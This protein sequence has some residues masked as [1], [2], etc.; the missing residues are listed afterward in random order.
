[1]LAKQQTK[2]NFWL[3]TFSGDSLMTAYAGVVTAAPTPS[4]SPREFAPTTRGGLEWPKWG[5]YFESRGNQGEKCDMEAACRL[6]DYLDEWHGV[7]FIAATLRWLDYTEKRA[8]LVVSRDGFILWAR[9]STRALRTGAFFRTS[10][11]PI[12]LPA[13]SLPVAHGLL[14]DGRGTADHGPGVWFREPVREMTIVAEQYDFA[15]SLLLLDDD[16][17]WHDA[18][19]EREGDVYDRFVPGPRRREW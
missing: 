19:E 16:A 8:V 12:E 18:D 17:A 1:M 2:E 11:E 4:A 14:V 7:S 15:L 10:R 3:R 9:S 5:M 13:A 6:L